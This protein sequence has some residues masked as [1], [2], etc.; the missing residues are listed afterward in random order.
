MIF[1]TRVF[2]RAK[3]TWLVVVVLIIIIVVVVELKLTGF[4]Y[5]S[6]FI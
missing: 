4:F 5:Y 6:H 2:S 1:G 3:Y